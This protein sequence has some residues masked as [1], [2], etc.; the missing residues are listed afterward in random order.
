MKPTLERLEDRLNPGGLIVMDFSPPGRPS[1]SHLFANHYQ[2][3]VVENLAAQRVRNLFQGTGLQVVVID[4]FVNQHDLFR[5]IDPPTPDGFPIGIGHPHFLVTI[6]ADATIF[7]REIGLAPLG[8]LIPHSNSAGPA[9]VFGG[10]L[11][12]ALHGN[13]GVNSLQQINLFSVAVGDVVAHETGHLMGLDHVG[14]PLDIMNFELDHILAATFAPW[15]KHYLTLSSRRI[16]C[17]VTSLIF[18]AEGGGIL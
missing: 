4:R 8:G 18:T 3:I 10:A 14:D 1:F 15:E 17:P 5:F 7:P 2:T 6:G 9:E 16:T 12:Q 11:F 13:Q